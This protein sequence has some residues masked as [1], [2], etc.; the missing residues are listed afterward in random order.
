MYKIANYCGGLRYDPRYYAMAGDTLTEVPNY[1]KSGAIPE[2]MVIGT[3]I[4]TGCGFHVDN[5]VF[6]VVTIGGKKVITTV[7]GAPQSII[8][9]KC[10]MDIDGDKFNIKQ[11]GA[12]ADNS[13]LFEY[14]YEWDGNPNGRIEAEGYPK[15]CLITEDVLTIED[16]EDSYIVCVLIDKNGKETY[17]KM[18]PDFVDEEESIL[19]KG[20]VPESYGAMYVAKIDGAAYKRTYTFPKA[21]VYASINNNTGKCVKTLRIYKNK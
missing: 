7:D 3:S 10:S 6:N 18:E 17:I 2:P 1:T 11:D 19:I 9:A 20:Y 5:G 16:L 8:K 21:G 14:N 4:K 12:M 13:E 15:L